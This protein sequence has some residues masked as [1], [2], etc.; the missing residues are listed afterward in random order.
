MISFRDNNYSGWPEFQGAEN[1][2]LVLNVKNFD[3]EGGDG[4]DK[5]KDELLINHARVAQEPLR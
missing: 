5:C 4:N 2:T 3:I 1:S